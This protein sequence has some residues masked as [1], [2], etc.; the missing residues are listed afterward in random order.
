M[1]LS[2]ILMSLF[3]ANVASA[4]PHL[5]CGAWYRPTMNGQSKYFD[6]KLTLDVAESERLY[7]E[8]YVGKLSVSKVYY[9]VLAV[10]GQGGAVDFS[11]RIQDAKNKQTAKSMGNKRAEVALGGIDTLRSHYHT[12]FCTS[13]KPREQSSI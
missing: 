11:L 12:L 5:D 2:L 1:K 13:V 6:M 8:V 3:L 9:D 4:A 7:T 10:V